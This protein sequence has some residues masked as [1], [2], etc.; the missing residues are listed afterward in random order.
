MQG[1]S[2]VEQVQRQGHN[3]FV[4]QDRAN[5]RI[6]GQLQPI[7]VDK[8][9]PNTAHAKRFGLDG[10]KVK[11]VVKPEAETDTE[12]DSSMGRLGCAQGQTC[13]ENQNGESRA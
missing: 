5:K 11:I 13:G 3:R 2:G 4:V 6:G 10:S 8:I 9:K 12:P 7:N 1:W